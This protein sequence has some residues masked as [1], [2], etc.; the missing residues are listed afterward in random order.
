MPYDLND[1][2]K[3]LESVKNNP[4]ITTKIIGSTIMGKQIPVLKIKSVNPVDTIEKK[5]IIIMARQHPG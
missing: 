4:K 3:L 2:Q 1:L 5:A